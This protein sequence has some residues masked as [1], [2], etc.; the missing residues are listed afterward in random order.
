MT[1]KKEQ[2]KN[3]LDRLEGKKVDDKKKS[4][5]R[6]I[7]KSKKTVETS[8]RAA[9]ARKRAIE[10]KATNYYINKDGELM[11]RI[12]VHLPFDMVEG[13]RLEAYNSMK[14]LS[15]LIREKLKP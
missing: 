14:S 4:R 1:I 7:P 10:G 2:I 13:L 8:E 9:R 15:E 3:R 12:L 11:Q 6:D 5:H